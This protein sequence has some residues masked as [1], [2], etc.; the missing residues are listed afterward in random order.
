[1]REAVLLSTR[2]GMSPQRL[3]SPPQENAERIE[4]QPNSGVRSPGLSKPREW[5]GE[6]AGKLPFGLE[7]GEEHPQGRWNAAILV[8]ALPHACRPHR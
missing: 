2:E 5:L 4:V 6:S 8:P 7:K 1:M 3:R